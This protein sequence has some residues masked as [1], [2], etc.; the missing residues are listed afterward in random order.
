MAN[1]NIAK[2]SLLIYLIQAIPMNITYQLTSGSDSWFRCNALQQAGS[3]VLVDQSFFC[4]NW[5][6][7]VP[8]ASAIWYGPYQDTLNSTFFK[9]F[10]I[11]GVVRIIT[12][13][14][15]ADDSFTL[16]LNT[17]QTNCQ[18]DYFTLGSGQMIIC[19]ITSYAKTGMNLLRIDVYNA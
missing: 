15:Q 4:D 5:V 14:I 1:R 9:Y 16:Y 17:K 8:G 11:P 7:E 18:A 6:I 10:F 13:S 2:L 12:A 3:S 19:D